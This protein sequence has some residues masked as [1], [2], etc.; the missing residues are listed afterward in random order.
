MAY[1]RV[2][3]ATAA[4]LLI[5]TAALVLPDHAPKM[6]RTVDLSDQC[7]ELIDTFDEAVKSVPA[8][9]DR[10]AAERLRRTAAQ[11]CFDESAPHFMVES[12][13]EDLQDALH[14][15]GVAATDRRR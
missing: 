8:S 9:D 11:E 5:V 1:R 6:A 7:R 15:I 10:T 4:P 12:G 3:V 14:K 2:L 13:I